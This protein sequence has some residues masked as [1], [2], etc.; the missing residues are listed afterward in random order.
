MKTRPLGKTGL[1]VAELALG[2]LFVSA[3]GA[4]YDF[5]SALKICLI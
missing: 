3:F 4:E 5:I 2:G 1:Q